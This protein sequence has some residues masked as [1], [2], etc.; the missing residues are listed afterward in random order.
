MLADNGLCIN[1]VQ[2]FTGV[3]FEVF[4]SF[5]TSSGQS[6]DQRT[7]INITLTYIL[8]QLKNASF[9]SSVMFYKFYQTENSSKSAESEL[10]IAHLGLFFR[11][12]LNGLDLLDLLSRMDGEAIPFD[13]SLTADRYYI[14]VSLDRMYHDLDTNN[15]FV[16]TATSL[17]PLEL[18]YSDYP[19]WFEKC[20]MIYDTVLLTKQSICSM[21][22]LNNDEFTT[23]SNGIR[24][25]ILE[26][27][28]VLL[29]NEFLF[30]ENNNS[31]EVCVKDYLPK[32]ERV[33]S[34][35]AVNKSYQNVAY[36]ISAKDIMSFWCTCLS[37]TCLLLTFVTYSLFRELRTPPGKNNMALVGCLIVA[38]SL[39]QFGIDQKSNISHWACFTIGLLIHFSWLSVFC[40]MNVCCIH[41]FRVFTHL[42][43]MNAISEGAGR[44]F[45]YFVYSFSASAVL[46]AINI[47]ASY[48]LSDHNNYGYVSEL[49]YISTSNMVTFTFAMPAAI[50]TLV[51][52]SLFSVVVI[53]LCRMPSMEQSVNK[54]RNY[55]KVYAKLSSITGATW[56]LGF[57]YFFIKEDILEFLFIASNASQGVFI[58][59]SFT[60]NKRVFNL[61]KERVFGKPRVPK[62]DTMETPVS[63][64]KMGVAIK[65]SN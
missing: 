27:E 22:E 54:T 32:A 1:M 53:Q 44:F 45:L 65:P 9:D 8:R 11:I 31:V 19:M 16:T 41:M 47:L 4:I 6:I 63:I 14:N 49:C 37:L 25:G 26:Y 23:D 10:L 58:F 59:L 50:I 57:L 40:W 18:I 17:I 2:H 5:T 62:Q 24:I 34:A 61:Y 55:F 28:E 7:F 20:P 33:A 48:Y 43:Q 60:T 30:M 15:Y 36:K 46:I 51:N 35:K 56:L 42:R 29:P 12:N 13:M 52:L 64:K 38:Q 39:F 3:C 21:V